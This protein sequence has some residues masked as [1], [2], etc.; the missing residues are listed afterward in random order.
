[1]EMNFARNGYRSH[2]LW[3]AGLEMEAGGEEETCFLLKDF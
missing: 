1:M 3:E 2:R